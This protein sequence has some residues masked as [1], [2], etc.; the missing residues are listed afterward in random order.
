MK[1]TFSSSNDNK[2]D[3][4]FKLKVEKTITDHDFSSHNHSN[5][6]VFDLK[7]LNLVIKSLN[8]KSSSDEDKIHNL[9]IQ[10]TTKEFRVIILTLI[11]ETVKQSTIPQSWKNFLIS[12]ILKNSRT[13]ALLKI[14][15]RSVLPVVLLN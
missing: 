5:K 10:N 1:Q 13:A 9:M 3:E 8:K 12:M 7:E 11:N 14:I 15:V 4:E 6:D 2:F